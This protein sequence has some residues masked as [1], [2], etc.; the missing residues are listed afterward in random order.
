MVSKMAD[1]RKHFLFNVIQGGF[2]LGLYEIITPHNIE[3][4]FRF[5]CKSNLLKRVLTFV[6][7]K[8]FV[9][10][11]SGLTAQCEI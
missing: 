5:W 10:D 9:I 7:R 6:Y 11:V 4:L 2:I 8:A 3:L 1:L